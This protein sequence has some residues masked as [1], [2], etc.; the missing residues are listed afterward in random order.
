MLESQG[1]KK[2]QKAWLMLLSAV[3]LLGAL[4][5]LMVSID[6]STEKCFVS[7]IEYI[8]G[9]EVIGY[10]ENAECICS[11]DGEVECELEDASK[12]FLSSSDFTT[13][14]LAF[15]SEFLNSLSNAEVNISEEIVF[16]SVS[17]GEDGLKI[18]TERLDLCTAAGVIPEQV[19]FFNLTGNDLVLTV[20]ETGDPSKFTEPCIIEN[21]FVLEKMTEKLNSTFK[22]YFRNEE[23]EVY[24]A[25]ICVYEGRVHNEGDSYRSDDETQLCSCESGEN[26]CSVI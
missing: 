1:M 26:L 10:L 15:S 12:S 19:G 23:D 18:V 25:D 16:R 17:Q 8:S 20:I 3:L 24:I 22:L 21:A 14:D 9:Q 13:K 4:I 6:W 2:I 7:G 5:T 11:R